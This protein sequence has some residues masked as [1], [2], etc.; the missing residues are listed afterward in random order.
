M[1]SGVDRINEKLYSFRKKYYLNLFLKGF[2]LSTSILLGY[3]LL[4]AVVE[5]NLW[6]PAALRLLLFAC[7]FVVT[8]WCIY[9]F[10]RQPLQWW[11]QQ[12][13]LSE[14]ESAKLIGAKMPGIRDHLLNFIQLSA[15]KNNSLATASLQQKSLEFEPVRF[16]E[17]IDLRENKKYLKFL[18]FP[19]I[20]LLSI[21]ILNKSILLQSTTRLIHFSREF[22]PEAPFAFHV[23]PK[24]L[25]A[26]YNEDLK[27]IVDLSGNAIPQDIYLNSSSQRIKIQPVGDGKFEHVF[28]NVQNEFD[29]QL[30]GAGFYSRDFHVSVIKRPELT[31]FKIGLVY[32]RYLQ[33]KDEQLTNAGN[34]EI[35]E[36][37]LV[38][39]T[40]STANT[41][42]AKIEFFVDSTSHAFKRSDHQILIAEKKIRKS[43]TYKISLQNQVSTNRDRIQYSIDVIKDLY[44]GISLTNLKDSI[45]YQRILLGGLVSD[46]HGLTKLILHYSISNTTDRTKTSEGSVP[47]DI[48]PNQAQQSFYYNWSLDS[49]HL[50]PDSRLEYYLEVWD[51]DAVNGKKSTRSARYNFNV[52][53][54]DNLVAEIKHSERQTEQKIE[55]AKAK[56]SK[57]HEQIEQANQKLK[58]KQSLDW[59]DR[60]MLDDIISE[61][62]KIQES[63]DD[64]KKQNELLNQKKE[65]F[66]E[67]DEKIKEKAE[68]IQKLMEELLDPETKKLFAELEKLLRENNDMNDLQKLMNKLDQNTQNLEKELERT[69]NLF[70]QLKFDFKLDQAIKEIEKNIDDQEN[71]LKE[72]EELENGKSESGRSEQKKEET[73][74][75]S[76]ALSKEQKDIKEDFKKTKKDLQELD[77]LGEELHKASPAPDENETDEV[78]NEQNESQEMLEKNDPS[79]SKSPQ[80]NSLQKMNKML[81]QMKSAQSSMEMEIDMENLESLRQIVHG[82]VKLSFD[83]EAMLKEFG[84][85][86]QSDPRFNVIAQRQLKLRDDIKVIED[87][88]QALASR[89]EMM[90]SI[91][92]KELGNL[93][94]HI[95]NV[96][97]ANK[98]R[99]RPQASGEMQATMASINNLALLLD[100]HYEMMMK[101]MQ[102]AKPGSGKGKPKKSPSLSEMQQQ[103]NEKIE[104]LKGSGK[105][106]RQLSEELAEMAAEQQRIRQAL[107][108]MQEKMENG[109]MPGDLP[110]KMEQTETELVNKQLTD[111]LIKR[112]QEILTRLLES[113]RSMREQEMDE[114]RKGETA[115]DYEKEMPKAFEEY[116]RLKEKEVELLKTVPP[117]LYPYYKK[118]VN[119]YFKRMGK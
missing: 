25:V 30:E 100:N 15:F 90:G 50:M 28:E 113:E 40:I 106:G 117:K 115:H 4:A 58:G 5:H 118:E 79:K 43:T 72:T 54:S 99:R 95:E 75:A 101:M 114:E 14:Q 13:G 93:N 65:S 8:G 76:E 112:Q 62:S 81:Q 78:E 9:H 110:G 86:L 22:S 38:K 68:Q 104:Q 16:D 119:E 103:L 87:S 24:S 107:R 91:I 47:L 6:L 80:K 88:L 33:K 70:K 105:S 41:D 12:K 73:K 46:D 92:T 20:L 61:K 94:V 49:L 56:S 19:I 116:L 35:P 63:I 18:F 31:Q 45:L 111:Q 60:K 108:E 84:E 67:Q 82:L 11:I 98:E 7:F 29:F 109:K 44:P 48:T 89:D 3:F 64:L 69:L 53:S 55:Q 36:G 59:Q 96:I 26:F 23:D 83:E 10:L 37:T 85:L 77:K 17:T 51:N 27:L 57:L 71:L 1:G 32:P 74:K 21:V 2:I 42:S 52:P 97:E 66:T 102:N 39:W 34:L